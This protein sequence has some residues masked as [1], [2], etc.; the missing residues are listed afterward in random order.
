M[1]FHPEI[2]ERYESI[3]KGE[4]RPS[5][6]DLDEINWN[7]RDIYIATL[8]KFPEFLDEAESKFDKESSDA[9]GIPDG[10]EFKLWLVHIGVIDD[11]SDELDEKLK[12]V[13][14]SSQKDLDDS[15]DSESDD[16][17]RLAWESEALKPAESKFGSTLEMDISEPREGFRVLTNS[18]SFEYGAVFNFYG[19]NES[20]T[21]EIEHKTVEVCEDK[22]YDVESGRFSDDPKVKEVSQFYFVKE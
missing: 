21:A 19:N 18:S 20:L 3:L 12:E 6:W 1:V 2:K 8:I 13:N 7:N 9:L 22:Y 15:R 11:V 16:K 10:A 14:E 5:E 4:I 17:D